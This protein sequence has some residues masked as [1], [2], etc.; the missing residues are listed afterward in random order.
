LIRRT[1]SPGGLEPPETLKARYS[2][3]DLEVFSEQELLRFLGPSWREL[4][5]N[6]LSV[7]NRALDALAWELVYRVEPHLYDRL[8]QGETLHPSIIE[9]MPNVPAAVEVGAGTGRWTL[10]LASKCE[11]IIAVEPAAPLRDILRTNLARM[12]ATKVDVVD[13]FFDDLPAGSASAELVTSCSAFTPHDS[14]GGEAGLKEMERVCAPGGLI[15]VVWPTEVEWFLERSF[16]HVE[17]EGEM[18]VDYGS[19]QEAQE[20]CSIFYPWAVEVAGA[21]GRLSYE[22]LHIKPPSDLM[23]RRV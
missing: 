3:G 10:P 19:R 5:L 6:D 21:G 13:G 7:W 20:I 9:W 22:D 8:I 15:V 12:G 17:F 2:P 16:N 1:D 23:W 4:D 11:R 14:H 18:F